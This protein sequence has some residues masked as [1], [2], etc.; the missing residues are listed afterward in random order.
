MAKAIVVVEGKITVTTKHAKL[1]DDMST[2][3][4]TDKIA[5]DRTNAALNDNKPTGSS[6]AAHVYAQTKLSYET[7][8][9]EVHNQCGPLT[10]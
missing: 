8:N 2:L 9:D 6:V 10:M 1:I 4:V 5:F 3:V 7:Y